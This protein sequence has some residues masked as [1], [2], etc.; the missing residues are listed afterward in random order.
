MY[1]WTGTSMR[2]ALPSGT[3][4]ERVPKNSI[5]KINTVLMRYLK[6]SMQKIYDEQN[7]KILKTASNRTGI[8]VREV[9]LNGA[10]VGLNPVFKALILCGFWFSKIVH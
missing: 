6:K 1:F 9:R 3:K 4:L 10:S 2:R 8:R 5:I 7:I